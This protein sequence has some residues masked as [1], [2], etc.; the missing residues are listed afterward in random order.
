MEKLKHDEVVEVLN[1][2]KEAMKHVRA[3]R[4][5]VSDTDIVHRTF[6]MPGGGNPSQPERLEHAEAT[7]SLQ[8]RMQGEITDANAALQDWESRA[9]KAEEALA[10]E[11]ADPARKAQFVAIKCRS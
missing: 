1:D 11:L 4:Y 2:S 3:V 5:G 6:G 7:A 9:R 8:V 10:R